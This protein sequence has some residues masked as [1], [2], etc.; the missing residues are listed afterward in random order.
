MGS[1]RTVELAHDLNHLDV[2]HILPIAAPATRRM[3]PSPSGSSRLPGRLS[4]GCFGRLAQALAEEKTH[5]QAGQSQ[6]DHTDQGHGERDAEQGQ[7]H[8][9]QSDQGEDEG[10]PQSEA[11][12]GAAGKG[13]ANDENTH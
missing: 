11:R 2:L 13:A 9:H 5:H 12:Q 8:Q 4:S 3:S 6:G 1:A 7:H 10:E